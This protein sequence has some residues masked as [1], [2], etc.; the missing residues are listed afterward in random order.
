MSHIYIAEGSLLGALQI[1]QL[2]SARGYL[3]NTLIIMQSWSI[4]TRVRTNQQEAFSAMLYLSSSIALDLRPLPDNDG[5]TWVPGSDL[6]LAYVYL[7]C[8]NFLKKYAIDAAT[9]MQRQNRFDQFKSMLAEGYFLYTQQPPPNAKFLLDWFHGWNLWYNMGKQLEQTPFVLLAEDCYWESYLR[10]PLLNESIIC[11]V[12]SMIRYKNDLKLRM[13]LEKAYKICPWNTY[14]RNYLIALDIKE[15]I[16]FNVWKDKFD[17]Q[18]SKLR[19]IQG[20]CRSFLIKL[21]WPESKI[22][23]LEIKKFHRKMMKVAEFRYKDALRRYKIELIHKWHEN[24]VYW[25]DLKYTSANIIQNAWR[26]KMAM[27]YYVWKIYRVQRAN[28]N[29]LIGAENTYNF[30]R[31]RHFRAWQD[32]YNLRVKKRSAYIITSVIMINGRNK[33][34]YKG[35]DFYLTT[36]RHVKKCSNRRWLG[37]WIDRYQ[38]RR[39]LH[40]T[41]T[42]RFW[43]RDVKRRIR[44]RE[45]EIRLKALEDKMRVEG[46]QINEL[47]MQKKMFDIWRNFYVI[48]HIHN[49][50]VKVAIL[51]PILFARQKARHIV[52]RK[53]TRLEGQKAYPRR[54]YLKRLRLMFRFILR[55]Q[56]TRMMQRFVRCAI[57]RRKLL[58]LSNIY[59]CIGLLDRKREEKGYSSIMFHWSKFLFLLK[60]ERHRMSRRITMFFRKLYIRAKVYQYCARRVKVGKFCMV[61]HRI[62]QLNSIRKLGEC[63]EYTFRLRIL[64]KFFYTLK[65]HT[66]KVVFGWLDDK[67]VKQKLLHAFSKLCIYKK[68]ERNFWARAYQSVKVVPDSKL[69]ISQRTVNYMNSDEP[70]LMYYEFVVPSKEFKILINTQTL[71][72]KKAFKSWIVRYRQ[73][74]RETRSGS[75]LGAK[76]VWRKVQ[77]NLL[78]R[79]SMALIMQSIVRARMAFRKANELKVKRRR[80]KESCTLLENKKFYRTFNFLKQV[81]IARKESRLTLQCWFRTMIAW[82]R[83]RQQ[84]K[85]ILHIRKAYKTL[86]TVRYQYILTSRAMQ[87]YQF[88]YCIFQMKKKVFRIPKLSSYNKDQV[89]ISSNDD[90][91]KGFSLKKQ[92]LMKHINNLGGER[93]SKSTL[94]TKVHGDPIILNLDK[95]KNSIVDFMSQEFHTY[96]FRLRQTGILTINM[97]SH[98]L[99]RNEI[100]YCI[101]NSQVV[102]IH[103]TNS[104]AVQDI[105]K[106][107]IGYKV[108]LLSGKLTEIDIDMMLKFL[109]KRQYHEQI[110]IHITDIAMSFYSVSLLIRALSPLI[111]NPILCVREICADTK[112]FGS[113]GIAQLLVSLK[114]NTTV[115]IITIACSD[116]SWLS[117]YG[118]CFNHLS[119]NN[120]I[121]EIRIYGALLGAP[122][123]GGLLQGITVGYAS[124]SLL[125]FG[126]A[127]QP[128]ALV[129]ADRVIDMAK[130]RVLS[131]RPGLSI[132]IHS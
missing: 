17:Y 115:E 108:A 71:Q 122:V 24:A 56:K 39:I 70:P 107:F 53:R 30:S 9:V 27:K 67:I 18:E 68:I 58:R 42:I 22:K 127:L 61:L 12:N 93:L 23:Y 65:R 14:I 123:I 32:L 94:K 101:Q 114:E 126:A 77:Y 103:N 48:R 43:I 118:H 54:S 21:H 46:I 10:S 112:S 111:H 87:S 29:F 11:Q 96:L 16:Q 62:I 90:I 6:N 35:M 106:N 117:V 51:L 5:N 116:S 75:L 76:Q 44:E 74:C 89:T 28:Y 100:Q 1:C 81:Q 13:L 34:F 20:I 7:F 36:M 47:P 60:R 88:V 73:K 80:E 79:A 129:L 120:T 125:E 72:M 2:A 52:R 95:N 55:L 59:S 105:C 98:G 26:R 83:F 128:Q 82:E 8:C 130:R 78:E 113:L 102:F 66:Q 33:S 49:C 131:G 19:K 69:D 25:L 121:K 92:K 119:A 91:C 110:I 124:L 104:N 4:L 3:E 31:V 132:T 50:R 15:N 85:Y 38:K 84:R 45:A 63:T 40:A 57:A 41:I 97:F 64:T 109:A 99:T 37:Y 86:N